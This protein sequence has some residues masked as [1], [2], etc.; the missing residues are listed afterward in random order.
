MA[1]N[2]KKEIEHLDFE[3]L[4]YYD[5]RL[6]EWMK[7]NGAMSEED[8]AK[9][10]RINIGWRRVAPVKLKVKNNGRNDNVIIT[11]E[12]NEATQKLISELPCDNGLRYN[13]EQ[14]F[15]FM[16]T[17]NFSSGLNLANQEVKRGDIV[18][19]TDYN[20]TASKIVCAIHIFK[21]NGT[22]NCILIGH[23]SDEILNEI[24]E[25]IFPKDIGEYITITQE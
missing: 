4:G 3:G 20:P 17:E 13:Y 1:T 5:E 10:D 23:A 14:K 8:K 2:K 7:K 25:K 18:L 12:D 9:L 15:S 16:L 22:S 6:K 19:T 11:L 21:A 24:D